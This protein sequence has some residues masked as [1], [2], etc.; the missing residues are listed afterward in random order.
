MAEENSR[1]HSNIIDN[2]LRKIDLYRSSD[3]ITDIIHNQF[4]QDITKHLSSLKEESYGTKSQIVNSSTALGTSIENA[5]EVQKKIYL[6]IGRK[7]ACSLFIFDKIDKP[8]TTVD[9]KLFYEILFSDMEYRDKEALIT[10][11]DNEVFHFTTPKQIETELKKLVTWFNETI[12]IKEK[13]ALVTIA[14]FHYKFLVIHPFSDGNGRIARLLLGINLMSNN[15]LPILI[16]KE[17]RYTYYK[18]L[19][20]ADNNDLSELVNFI[21]SKQESVLKEF[22]ESSEFI[23]IVTKHEVIEQLNKIKGSTKCFILSEDE[24]VGN[25]LKIVFESSQFKMNETKFLSYEGCTKIDSVKLFAIFLKEKFPHIEIIVH[26]DRD[27]LPNITIKKLKDNLAKI[28]VS[29]FTTIGTD[30][31]SHFINAAHINECH[32]EITIQKAE[33]IITS[34]LEAV[35]LKSYVLLKTQEFGAKHKEKDTHLEEAIT[36]IFNDNKF[37]FSHGKTTLKGIKRHIQELT[38]N[39]SKLDVPTSHLLVQELHDISTKIWHK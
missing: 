20:A 9:I 32:P 28:N 23:S 19:Q 12:A 5:V 2:Y 4:Q 27:Y 39:N 13:P 3:P 6:D 14:E 17:D 15:Y 29:L 8:L 1:T 36:K 24:K 22:I 26:R 35:K 21:I 38:K 30:I 33:E 18:A 37:R 11:Q 31:E 7:H 16:T 25:L 10:N 34:E